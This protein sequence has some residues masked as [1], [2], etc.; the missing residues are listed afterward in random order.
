[1]LFLGRPREL[2]SSRLQLFIGLFDVVTCQRAIKETA[3]AGSIHRK[4][5]ETR[6]G[7]PDA[8]FNPALLVVERLISHQLESQFVHVKSERLVLITRGY[9]DEFDMGNHQMTPLSS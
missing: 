9:A 5:H 6:V 1:M 2:D 7:T 3:D 8:H 4:Q